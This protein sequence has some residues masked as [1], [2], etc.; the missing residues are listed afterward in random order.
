MRRVLPGL[1]ALGLALGA[2][3]AA[4]VLA[5]PD[6][7]A[8]EAPVPKRHVTDEEVAAAI[9]RGV[10]FLVESQNADGS[11]GS[12]AP[13]LTVDIYAPGRA[14]YDAYQVGTSGLAVAGLVAAHD[15]RPGTRAAIRKGEDWLVLHHAAKRAAP[16]VVYNTWAHAYALEA[17]AALLPL[18]HDPV[19]R[20]RLEAAAREAV[21]LLQHYEYV[22]GG[23][24]YYDFNAQTQTP[25][26]GYA[27]S[28]TTAAVL[29]ALADIEKQGIEVPG[30]MVRRGVALIHACRLPGGAYAYSF[31]LDPRVPRGVNHPM[32]SLARTPACLACLV[33]SGEKVAETRLVDALD[34]LDRHGHFLA[35]ARKYPIPHESWFQNSGYFFLYGYAYASL[36]LDHVPPDAREHHR[37][38]IADRLVPLQ[39]PDGSWWDYQLYRYHKPY[40]T[41]YTLL[42]LSRC[43]PAGAVGPVGAVGAGQ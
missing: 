1:L 19:R 21:R 42:A 28:F 39:E 30:R 14:A 16:D 27:T 24:G 29:V 22:D 26:Y 43:G 18:E 10:D 34:R 9:T 38:A 17:F 7:T 5:R 4:P 35:I 40:G 36:L 3:D 33:A 8:P 20:A 15:D 2:A 37:H 31:T 41:G 6:A 25:S 13:T 12:T 11:W 23:W 32:G